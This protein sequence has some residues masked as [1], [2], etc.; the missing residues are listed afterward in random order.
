MSRWQHGI[1]QSII[2]AHT[3]TTNSTPNT[4]SAARPAKNRRLG[5]AV[6]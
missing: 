5:R 6:V 2:A 1:E 4:T 3:G